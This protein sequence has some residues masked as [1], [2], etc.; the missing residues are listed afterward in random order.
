[1]TLDK[2]RE[3]KKVIRAVIYA[4]FSSDNQRDESID[5][6]LRA[7]HEYAQRND[8]LIIEEYIDRARSA[9]TDNRPEFL[10]MIAD[11]KKETFDVV[12]VHKLDRFARNRYDSIGYRMELK[13]HHV[14]L[15][16]V[17]EHLDDESPESL[18]LES[19]LEAMAEYYSKNLAREVHKGLRENSLKTKHTGGLPPLGYNVDPETRQLVINE[20]NAEAVRLIF[21][22]YLD[23]VG[24]GGIAQELTARGFRSQLGKVFSN[25]AIHDILANE[26]YAGVYVFNK[27]SAKDV[28]GKRNSHRFKDPEETIRIEGAVPAIVSREDFDA[29]QQKMAARKHKRTACNAKEVYL[30]SGKIICGECGSSYYGNRKCC[31]RNKTLMITYRCTGRQKKH[32]CRNKEIRREYI[33]AFVLEKLS[34]YV[35]NESM[36]PY[37]TRMYGAYLAE[38]DADSFKKRE[39][40][41]HSIATLKK[42]IDNLLLLAARVSSDSLAEKLDEL[43]T[44][45]ARYEAE[46]AALCAAAD[47]PELTEEAVRDSFLRAQSLFAAGQLSTTKK[48]IELYV[49]R[50]VI[51]ADHVEARFIPHPDLLLPAPTGEAPFSSEK[52]YISAPVCVAELGE[53]AFASTKVNTVRI[54]EGNIF[55]FSY[56]FV[57][58]VKI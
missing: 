6:Q 54:R 4:R 15:I 48:L 53:D 2:I 17:L 16:S 45:K 24:Y 31:G 11:S 42:E 20:H 21:Q 14:S 9:T 52:G 29:V 13:R 8:I 28:D 5:A 35:F 23:G 58:S 49:D 44:V 1:M 57:L 33:E 55:V 38:R 43:E 7:I 50:V 30:L 18:I 37:L 10:R 25:N 56:G 26:K 19:V 27:A 40:L 39:A 3:K 32:N 51:Y 34:A 36:I 41:K 46:Y 22:L 47:T 12:L